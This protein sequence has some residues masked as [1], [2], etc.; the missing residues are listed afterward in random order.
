MPGSI[1]S[2]WYSNS[3]ILSSF[4]S[5]NSPQKKNSSSVASWRQTDAWLFPLLTSFQN[6]Q[7]T[8]WHH[9]QV[10]N[11]LVITH[12]WTHEFNH[13]Y[14]SIFCSSYPSCCSNYSILWP[15]GI[16]SGLLLS[17]FDMILIIFDRNLPSELKYD[18]SG[19]NG[20]WKIRQGIIW[21]LIFPLPFGL[22]ALK[23][24]PTQLLSP[25]LQ[26]SRAL[27]PL[28]VLPKSSLLCWHFKSGKSALEVP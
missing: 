1:P 18:L 16:S 2:W 23:V 21:G 7:V 14:L 25:W 11:F 4:I 22:K 19:Q 27:S 12:E 28:T 8:L 5:W 6:N 24:S 9:P 10:S 20:S 26:C 3:T 13:I 15:L 17:L